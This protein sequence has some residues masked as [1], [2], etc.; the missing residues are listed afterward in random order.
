MRNA[1]CL[2]MTQS[3]MATHL[4]SLRSETGAAQSLESTAASLPI[5][6]IASQGTSTAKL[7]RATTHCRGFEAQEQS[8]VF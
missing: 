1:F 7:G 4:D 6:T 3:L 5:T 2:G 8:P